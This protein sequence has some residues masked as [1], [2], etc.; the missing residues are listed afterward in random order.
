MTVTKA[1][2][3][4]FLLFLLLLLDPRWKKLSSGIRDKHPGFATLFESFFQKHFQVLCLLVTTSVLMPF[5][6]KFI[7]NKKSWLS[8]TLSLMV[9]MKRLSSVSLGNWVTC[10]TSHLT[11]LECPFLKA[12]IRQDTFRL[13]WLSMSAPKRKK[14]HGFVKKI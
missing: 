11:T 7:V 10:L 5:L 14:K 6:I 1:R 4:L 3:I 9:A 8:L 2:Q 12:A 13:S